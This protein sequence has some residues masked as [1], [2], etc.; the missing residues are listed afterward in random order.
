MENLFIYGT[1]CHLSLL[2]KV[3]GRKPA[4]QNATLADHAVFWA[5]DHDFPLIVS[6]AGHKAHGLLLT[7]LTAEDFARL[8]Y[9]EGPFGY[10]TR[11]K[12]VETTGGDHCEARVYIPDEGLWQPG[13]P[14]DLAL[15]QARWGDIIVATAGDVMAL[16]PQPIARRRRQPMLM[17]G[18]SR[19]RAAEPFVG[20]LR[21]ATTPEDVT[22]E[23]FRAPYADFFAVEEYDLRYRRF[24]GGNGPLVKRAVFITGDAVTVLPYDPIRDRVLLIEQFRPAPFARGD[25]QP[26]LLEV[27]A[28][29]IDPGET[30]E[31]AA[32]REAGEEAGLTL[33]S[34]LPITNYYPSAGTMTEYIYSFV[35]LTGLPDE[36]AIVAGVANE[37]EDIKGH[38]IDFARL[39]EL[40]RSGEA[41]TAPLVLSALWL[42]RERP[43]LRRRAMDEDGTGAGKGAGDG[44]GQG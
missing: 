33:T 24:A 3:L 19:L 29:R 30:P 2:A 4:M 17:R 27:V 34:L 23:A 44:A 8:D 43:G 11:H 15:W 40:V 39:M 21:Q 6:Q 12:Q 35:A 36:V 16:Y 22:V 42:E 1:L 26:W 7:D 20:S 10:F 38:I 28:G 9:Y 31:D 25:G 41:N 18:A 37:A 32:R 13:E 5:K 14:W